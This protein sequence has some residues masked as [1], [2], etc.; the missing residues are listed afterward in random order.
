MGL[1]KNEVGDKRLKLLVVGLGS[2]GKRRVRNLQYLKA[3][4]II[5]F[6]IRE[7]RRR[8]TEE[9]YKIKTF[10]D[11]ENALSENPNAMIISTPPDLHVKYALIAAQRNIHFFTE[12]NVVDEGMDEL[13]KLIKNKKIVAAPSCSMRFHP[14]I[15]KIKELID[16]GVIGRPLVFTY[17]SGLYLPDWH[18]WE[19]YRKFYVARRATGAAR[20]ILPFELVWLT[21][22]FGEVDTISCMKGK[23]SDLDVDIDDVYQVL[24]KFREDILGHLLVDVVARAP[25][26]IFRLLG[27]RGTIEWDWNRKV[28]RV[29]YAEKK[30]WEEHQIDEGKPEK[31]YIIGEGMYIE[32]M[33][34]FLMAIKGTGNY[35]YTFEDDRKN[36]RLLYAAEKSS[37]TGVHIKVMQ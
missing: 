4:E 30:A 34:A 31:G 37:D 19:D 32:E 25:T 16:S 27:D 18:P 33:R 11:F 10:G 3:G 24:L 29:Y 13:L 2:M 23:V 1:F 21:W 5:G 26:R 9:K 22:V 14:A 35:P 36:L 28:V 15:K 12:A 8:E 7:D 20:E 6:D 17:H